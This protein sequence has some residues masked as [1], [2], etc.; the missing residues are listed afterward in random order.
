MGDGNVKIKK[1]LEDGSVEEVTVKAEEIAATVAANRAN[2]AANKNI[3]T[4]LAD[5]IKFSRK[6]ASDSEGALKDFLT[7]GGFGDSSTD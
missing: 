2:D 7:S 5:V 4:V 1:T 3:E 6:D